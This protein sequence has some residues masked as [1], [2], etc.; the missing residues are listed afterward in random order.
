MRIQVKYQGTTQELEL[1]S[2]STVFDVIRILDLHPDGV[3]VLKGGTVIPEDTEIVHEDDLEII[4][5]AS[6]G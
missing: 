3:I 1:P 5:I 6:G 4:T 2:G